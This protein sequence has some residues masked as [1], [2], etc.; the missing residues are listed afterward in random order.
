VYP[1]NSPLAKGGRIV[2]RVGHPLAV[3][4]PELR[5][6]RVP[7]DVL[8]FTK[9]ASQKHGDAYR[10]IT[11]VVMSRIE[12]LLDPEYRTSSTKPGEKSEGMR[13]FL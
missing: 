8:P 2:Y 9:E 4:G 7:R 12:E 6:W 3:D 10:A 1:G 13:R 5:E 11:D